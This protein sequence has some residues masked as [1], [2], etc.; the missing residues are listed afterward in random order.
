MVKI[1]KKGELMKIIDGDRVLHL[2]LNIQWKQ[3]SASGEI[4]F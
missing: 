1:I 3:L 2:I 4:R